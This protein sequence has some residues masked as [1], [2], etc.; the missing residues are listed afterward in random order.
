M[1]HGSLIPRPFE[2]RRK[3][4]VHTVYACEKFTEKFL[5]QFARY[6]LLSCGRRVQTI[7]TKHLK[8]VFYLN[9]LVELAS[10]LDILK[11]HGRAELIHS[12]QTFLGFKDQTKP[13]WGVSVFKGVNTPI[14]PPPHPPSKES[15]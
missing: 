1:V 5:V 9:C 8:S 12:K 14:A 11:D 7:Y 15:L 10:G 3:G 2:G 4:L 13:R 6:Q